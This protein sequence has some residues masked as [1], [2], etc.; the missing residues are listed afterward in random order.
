MGLPDRGKPRA[1]QGRAGRV[2]RAC[3][4]PASAGCTLRPHSALQHLPTLR[5]Q[6]RILA[7]LGVAARTR[8]LLSTACVAP[9]KNLD[10]LADAVDLLG[11]GHLL[12][13]VG[14]GPR[15]P[16]PTAWVNWP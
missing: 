10:M 2:L 9:E 14:A 1:A 4:L 5:L 11:Q 3:R 7:H 13:A 12:V 8:L 15:P 6:R 16:Q